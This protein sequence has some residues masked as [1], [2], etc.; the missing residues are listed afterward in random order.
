M[1]ELPEV[2]VTRLRLAPSWE[3]R[4]IRKVLASRP[5]YFFLTPPKELTHRLEGRRTRNLVRHGKY[6]L[7]D[8]DDGSRLLCHLGMTGQLFVAPRARAETLAATDPHVHLVLFLG[9]PASDAPDPR[10]DLAVVF[11]DVR[12][13]GKVQWLA[14]GL[15]SPRLSKM[16]PD[17]LTVDARTLERA[18]SQR[19]IPV[20]TALLDQAVLAGVGN[21]YADE[22]LFFARIAPTRPARDLTLEDCRNLIKGLRTVLRAAIRAGGS[23]ISDFVGGDGKPGRYQQNHR[24]YGREGLPCPRCGAPIARSVLG[25][26][27]T[28]FCPRCQAT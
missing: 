6:L 3:G 18:L 27:S 24:V 16:G 20:K 13:F 21:I 15:A 28:H 10:R 8:L 11:R 12:K 1:P 7:A 23:T 5:S 25:Q 9:P 22:A 19:S 4:R 14:P 17:A 2:E 26:R